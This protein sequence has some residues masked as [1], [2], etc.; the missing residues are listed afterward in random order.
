MITPS[1]AEQIRIIRKRLR[2][3]RWVSANADQLGANVA[4]LAR[5]RDLHEQTLQAL[6]DRR[7]QLDAG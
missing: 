3:N 1:T 2:I 6:N 4:T 7:A 5:Y